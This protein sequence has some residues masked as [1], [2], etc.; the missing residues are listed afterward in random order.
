MYRLICQKPAHFLSA[1]M[2]LV[3]TF[4]QMFIILGMYNFELLARSSKKIQEAFESE[5]L[6]LASLTV[7]LLPTASCINQVILSGF[8][9]DSNSISNSNS[10]PSSSFSALIFVS[11]HQPMTKNKIPNTNFFVL[12]LLSKKEKTVEPL[13]F[14]NYNNKKDQTKNF[15]F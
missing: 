6:L 1:Q 12:I 14:L 8:G 9:S 3:S 2:A 4:S 10:S 5:T 11:L 7:S 13:F 15:G